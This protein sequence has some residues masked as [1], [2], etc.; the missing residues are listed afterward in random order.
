VRPSKK[1]DA[2]T[3]QFNGLGAKGWKL[4]QA[5]SGFWCFARMKQN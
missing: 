4:K 5:D 2:M 1:P 3:A